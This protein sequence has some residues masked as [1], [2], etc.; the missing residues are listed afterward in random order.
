[1]PVFSAQPQATPKRAVELSYSVQPKG[2]GWYWEVRKEGELLGH[3]LAEAA[4][5]ATVAAFRFGF[6]T[7]QPR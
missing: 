4:V 5:A 2:S 6:D 7:Y 3:G 1:M